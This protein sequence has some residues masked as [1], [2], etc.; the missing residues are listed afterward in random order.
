MGGIAAWG[1]G[2]MKSVVIVAILLSAMV[3]GVGFADTVGTGFAEYQNCIDASSRNWHGRDP[4]GASFCMGVVQG[5]A[6]TA[7]GICLPPGVA[8]GQSLLVVLNYMRQY[9]Q[10]LNQDLAVVARKAL[11]QAW[12]CR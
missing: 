1:R 6:S 12:P 2:T 4:L 5:V 9:P 10:E 3:P 7:P 11:V 8:V